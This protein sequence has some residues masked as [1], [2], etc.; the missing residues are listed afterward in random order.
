MNKSTIALMMAMLSGTAYA[1]STQ[2]TP[3]FSPESVTV[4]TSAGMLSGKSHEM[5]Y[6]TG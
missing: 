1:D 2:L 4:S 3:N 6:D 5:V